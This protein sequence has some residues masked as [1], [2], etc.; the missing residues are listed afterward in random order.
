MPYKI[1]YFT[2]SHFR[3]TN[4]RGRKDNF[5]QSLIEKHTEIAE[6]SH[7]M[8]PDRI[9]HGG[10]LFDSPKQ[11]IYI[12][13]IMKKIIQASWHKHWDVVLGNHEWRGRWEDWKDRS[14]LHALEEDGLIRLYEGHLDIDTYGCRIISRHEQYV[15]KPVPWP[16]IL[17]KNYDGNADVF[18]VSDYHPFQGSKKVGD[19]LFVAPGAISRATRTESDLTRTPKVA[20]ITIDETAKVK[21]KFFKLKSAKP[22][23]EVFIKD[24]AKVPSSQMNFQNAIDNLKALKDEIKLYSVEDVVKVVA[25]TTKASQRVVDA[26]LERLSETSSKS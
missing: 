4:P 15:E 21:V 13:N 20:Y 19:T 12:Y 22:A 25:A 10:D 17:W 18:L 23:D 6:M 7:A 11:S 26:C 5:L 3:E 2:D 24:L 14:A 16:H 1:L 8:K 9:I